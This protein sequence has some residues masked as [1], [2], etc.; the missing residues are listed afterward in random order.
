MELVLL[1]LRSPVRGAGALAGVAHLAGITLARLHFAFVLC[2]LPRG[3]PGHRILV[4]ALL[5]VPRTLVG[6]LALRALIAALAVH[7]TS[8]RSA[9]LLVL[10][11][12]LCGGNAACGKKRKRRN[13]GQQYVLSVLHQVLSFPVGCLRMPTRAEGPFLAA[14]LAQRILAGKVSPTLVL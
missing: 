4:F 3:L 8:L 10:L 7:G 9:A 5:D 13:A 2:V 12:L 14:M 6:S 1:T 11:G